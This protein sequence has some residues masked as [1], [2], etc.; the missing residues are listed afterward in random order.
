MICNIVSRTLLSLN[1]TILS[2]PMELRALREQSPRN[3]PLFA[4]LTVEHV[5]LLDPAKSHCCGPNWCREDGRTFT[6]E[7]R[8][9]HSHLSLTKADAEGT[10]PFNFGFHL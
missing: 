6:S 10:M 1:S 4:M 2:I 9:D 7:P 5:V 3:T 8:Q